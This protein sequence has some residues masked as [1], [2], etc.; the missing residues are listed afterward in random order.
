MK[1]MIQQIMTYTFDN[2][3]KKVHRTQKSSFGTLEKAI[4]NSEMFINKT[5]DWIK[6]RTTV[7]RI[8]IVNKETNETL[9]TYKA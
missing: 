8:E 5:E 2:D 1:K 4:E 6:G 9:W 3:E 7:V